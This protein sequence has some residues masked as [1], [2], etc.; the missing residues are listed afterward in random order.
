MVHYGPIVALNKINLF[1]LKGEILAL[2]GSNGAGKST[3]LKSVIGIKKPTKG[4]ICYQG[5]KI[6]SLSTDRITRAGIYLV[7]EDRGIF[8]TLTVEENLQLGAYYAPNNCQSNF[9]K[10][11]QLFPILKK[12]LKQIA[13]TLSGGEQGILSFGK[14]LM[15]DTNILML[16]E[17]SLGLSPK[18]I[19]QVFEVIKTLNKQGY[20]I[21]LAEQN[22]NQ[23]LNY[24]H[25]IY[26]L[27]R[28]KILLYGKAQELK[29]H[30]SIKDAYLGVPEENE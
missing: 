12:R 14:A 8:N 18:L 21:L 23:S 16:D 3:L 26:V 22:V 13:G 6:N 20:T 5:K 27:E 29:D 28:G 15:A 2:F 30:P 10:T 4:Y 24:A 1:L 25:R 9:D 17:P 7:P 19:V 11:I